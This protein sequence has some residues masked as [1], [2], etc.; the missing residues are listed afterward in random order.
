MPEAVEEYPKRPPFYAY[1]LTRLMF[2]TA[3]AN[4]IGPEACHMI[5][6]IAH[7]EDATHYS[8]PVKFYNEQLMPVCGFANVKAL[9]RARAKAVDAGWLRYIPGGK[10]VAGK[11][12]TLVPAKYKNWEDGPIDESSVPDELEPLH[13]VSLPVAG[14]QTGD[15][16]ET[17]GR[18]TPD[19]RATINPKP[20]IHICTGESSESNPQPEF[21]PVKAYC[22]N[23]AITGI[24]IS[25]AVVEYYDQPWEWEVE[26]VRQWNELRGVIRVNGGSLDPPMRGKLQ[27]RLMDPSWFWKR[28]FGNFPLPVKT[29][30][31]P[32]MPW[33]LRYDSVSNILNGS[34]QGEKSGAGGRNGKQK[35][36]AGGNGVT[37]SDTARE[38]NPNY[39]KFPGMS[40]SAD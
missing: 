39:G 16:R 35:S 25:G 30:W 8:K 37:Y 22:I 12:W 34:F 28:A 7:T 15:K 31:V 21:I 10:G 24:E 13:P 32:N 2:K 11:Y 40:G 9:D 27:E 17:N 26:F 18:Q 4:D 20:E 33:F 38:R 5:I 19:K 3:L 6:Q 29:D 36:I 14:N 23:P 1:K